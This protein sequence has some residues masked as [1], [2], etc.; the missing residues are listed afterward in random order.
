[1]I[2]V[3]VL[4]PGAGT[5]I[6]QPPRTPGGGVD[7]DAILSTRL[8]KRVSINQALAVPEGNL[9]RRGPFHMPMGDRSAHR[10]RP[11]SSQPHGVAK[12]D[13][14]VR[15][16]A[17]FEQLE[18]L[19]KVVGEHPLAAPDEHRC[20]ED[21]AFVDQAGVPCRGRYVGTGDVEVAGPRP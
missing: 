16:A 2:D 5:L 11:M 14:A 21:V 3:E 1:M 10:R 17:L 7:H 19:A 20:D 18:W 6:K 8:Q 4:A 15:E 12:E 13:H 9:P